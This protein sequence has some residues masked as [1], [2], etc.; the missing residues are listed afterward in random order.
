M[1]ITYWA[2]TGNDGAS[3]AGQNSIGYGIAANS[4]S[5]YST[6]SYQRAG[7]SVIGGYGVSHNTD[8]SS[9][10]VR[11]FNSTVTSPKTGNPTG[12]SYIYGAAIDS[13][14]NGYSAGRTD[15]VAGV[16][17]ATL[18]KHN[19]SGTLQWSRMITN[20][21]NQAVYYCVATDST[22]VYAAGH[23]QEVSPGGTSALIVKYD[24]SGNIQWQRK[25]IDD[26]GATGYPIDYAYGI[27]AD[28]SG[29]VYV[30]GALKNSNDGTQPYLVKYN[31]SGTLQWQVTITSGE[32]AAGQNGTAYAL[33]LDSSGNP[34]ITGSQATSAGSVVTGFVI[35]YN[36]SGTLQWQRTFIQSSGIGKAITVDSSGNVY[37]AGTAYD[38]TLTRAY[39]TLIKY[40]SSGTLQW[41]RI[42]SDAAASSSPSING[43]ATDSAGTIYVTGQ[44]RNSSQGGQPFMLHLPAD[45]SKTGTITIV[46]GVQA[47]YSAGSL[48]VGNGSYTAATS[49]FLTSSTPTYT[50]SATT[51]NYANDILTVSAV[52]I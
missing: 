18:N 49:T 20:I 22:Y 17:N 37:A 43:I 1:S 3:A 8:G 35:K 47:V 9:S 38:N 11:G 27:A 26:K 25:L 5:V 42:L 51:Q 12:S 30:A 29:N 19:S 21:N 32:T 7:Y 14:N 10:F 45:G 39:G 46:S 2:A 50:E 40:N 15:V 28:S 6:G 16:S 36:S 48:T 41:Q 13:S 34:H 44:F 33:A 4:S 24:T 52:T 31:S 23:Q